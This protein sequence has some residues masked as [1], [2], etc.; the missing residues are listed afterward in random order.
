MKKLTSF[1]RTLKP[2]F[3]DSNNTS[4]EISKE[5]LEGEI[6][7]RFI[8]SDNFKDKIIKKEKLKDG[9]I[10]LPYRCGVSLQREIYSNEKECTRFGN[11]INNKTLVGFVLFKKETF[12]EVTSKFNQ[13]QDIAGETNL[14]ETNLKATP[15]DEN[16]NEINLEN[17]TVTTTDSGN[18]SHADIIYINPNGVAYEKPNPLIRSFSKKL[19]IQSKL[20]LNTINENKEYNGT[21]F[22]S[23]FD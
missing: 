21:S 16:F 1:I 19:Y 6:L 15:L 10:F 8:F 12:E 2:F 5:I 20:V 17:T 9:F 11:A 13:S 3:K 18:P 4:L 23:F 14:L 7:V 22:K